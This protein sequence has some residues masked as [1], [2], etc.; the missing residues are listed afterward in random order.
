MSGALGADRS[1]EPYSKTLAIAG[2]LIPGSLLQATLALCGAPTYQPAPLERRD[3]FL[4]PLKSGP[5]MPTSYGPVCTSGRILHLALALWAIYVHLQSMPFPC[6][7]PGPLCCQG[8]MDATPK[9]HACCS[10]MMCRTNVQVLGCWWLTPL[11]ASTLPYE[12]VITTRC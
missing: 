2:F 12:L 10:C 11:G 8:C 5:R 9:M 4:R 3:I 1:S 7:L 6:T